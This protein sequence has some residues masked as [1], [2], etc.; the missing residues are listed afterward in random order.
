MRLL[1]KS[2]KGTGK[3]SDQSR[4]QVSE[5]TLNFAYVRG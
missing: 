3:M 5:S 2:L 1:A 4:E